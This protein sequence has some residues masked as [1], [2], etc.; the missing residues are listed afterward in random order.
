MLVSVSTMLLSY[1]WTGHHME[2][3][4]QFMLAYSIWN[5]VFL[6]S[7]FY[8][9][10]WTN[11]WY[12]IVLYIVLCLVT[13]VVMLVLIKNSVAIS[14]SLKVGLAIESVLGITFP[15]IVELFRARIRS[16]FFLSYLK[17]C[18]EKFSKRCSSLLLSIVN[19][20]YKKSKYLLQLKDSNVSALKDGETFDNAKLVKTLMS[21]ILQ[22]SEKQALKILTEDNRTFKI[23]CYKKFCN[24]YNPVDLKALDTEDDLFRLCFTKKKD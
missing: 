8:R 10:L 1:C 21:T 15:L 14:H 13:T 23:L 4:D 6:I 2:R 18:R 19:G 17:S 16:D 7:V 24:Y 11:W 5:F 22:V 20:D 9:K 3:N 12:V